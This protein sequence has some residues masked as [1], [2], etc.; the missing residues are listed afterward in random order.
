[1]PTLRELQACFVRHE[2]KHEGRPG[3]APAGGNFGDPT[4]FD[5][6]VRVEAIDQAQGVRFL[7]PA[8]F[9][10]NGGARGTH[11][12]V[13]WSRSRGVPDDVDPKPG[14][15]TLHGTGIDDLTLHGDPVGHARSVQ[16]HGGC[17]WH[18]FVDNGSAA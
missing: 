1:M 14:R 10:K 13:C 2:R 11:M 9:A 7:C 6:M 8:C 18:G 4:T 5:A 17:G 15:W 3:I 16:L 12:V